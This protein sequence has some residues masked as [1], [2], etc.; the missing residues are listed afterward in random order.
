[1]HEL[2]CQGCISLCPIYCEKY[3][4][5]SMKREHKLAKLIIQESKKTEL[6]QNERFLIFCRNREKYHSR[7]YFQTIRVGKG[8]F[9]IFCF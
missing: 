3:V 9:F 5:H 2:N 1:M 8:K 6:S 7:T 4:I